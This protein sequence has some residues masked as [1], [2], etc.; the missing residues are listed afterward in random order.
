MTFKECSNRASD[1]IKQVMEG[2]SEEVTTD[3]SLKHE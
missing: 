3:L 1:L 2:F